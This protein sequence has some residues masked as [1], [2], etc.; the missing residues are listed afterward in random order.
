MIGRLAEKNQA[1]QEAIRTSGVLECFTI[2]TFSSESHFAR[3]IE[4]SL[5]QG[6]CKAEGVSDSPW[7]TPHKDPA[8]HALLHFLGRDGKCKPHRSQLAAVTKQP[9]S[10]SFS[11]LHLGGI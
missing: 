4:T 3:G 10:P 11:H 9:R 6:G 1:S 2:Q 7:S 8:L 5:L